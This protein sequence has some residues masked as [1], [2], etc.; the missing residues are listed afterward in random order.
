MLPLWLETRLASLWLETR[1]RTPFCG[2][3]PR[4][5]RQ[6]PHSTLLKGVGRSLHAVAQ[7]LGPAFAIGLT[8]YWSNQLLV[9]QE[10]GAALQI[11]VDTRTHC[12]P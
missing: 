4:Y 6:G 10:N 7:L 11:N 12:H 9:R 5:G 8:S 1:P 2:L 3:D